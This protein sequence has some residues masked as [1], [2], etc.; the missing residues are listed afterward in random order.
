MRVTDSVGIKSRDERT[1]EPHG[2][3]ALLKINYWLKVGIQ[4]NFQHS[5]L[6]CG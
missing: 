1:A 2:I 5:P 3:R 4:V 6:R